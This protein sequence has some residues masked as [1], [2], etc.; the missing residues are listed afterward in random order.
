MQW[1]PPGSSRRHTHTHPPPPPRCCFPTVKAEGEKAGTPPDGGSGL[2]PCLWRGLTRPAYGGVSLRLPLFP[3]TFGSHSPPPSLPLSSG[4]AG[5]SPNLT[6]SMLAG[7]LV[8]VE[9]CGPPP[10][11]DPST[12][13][14]PLTGGRSALP[15]QDPPDQVPVHA[16]R[17]ER[18][19]QR[20]PGHERPHPAPQ[21]QAGLR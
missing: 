11:G 4:F 13:T 18:G 21:V 20:D 17:P 12:H 14:L 16:A 5:R 15:L 19:G 3:V 8:S 6:H 9:P 1:W 10:R 2:M 7:P